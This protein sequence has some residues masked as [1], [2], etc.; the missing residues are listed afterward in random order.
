MIVVSPLSLMSSSTSIIFKWLIES[1][2]SYLVFNLTSCK[3]DENNNFQV[4]FL[5][6]ANSTDA[7]NYAGCNELCR[8]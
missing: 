8:F 2:D 5:T 1:V 4:D 6:V 7:K 3:F